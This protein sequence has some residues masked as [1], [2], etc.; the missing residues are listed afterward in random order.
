MPNYKIISDFYDTLDAIYFRNKEHS[1]RT[2]IIDMIPNESVC[3]LDVCAGTCSN[4]VLIAQNK[5]KAKITALDLSAKMLDIAEE[6][7]HRH[8]IKNIKTI[9]ADAKNSGLPSHSFDVIII[10]LVLHEMNEH[11]Q[12]A[13][14]SEAKR[15]LSDNGNIV[16]IEWEQ[17]KKLHQRFIFT[18]IKQ[19]EPKGFKYFL[20]LDLAEYFENSGFT[21]LEKRSCD[22]T[23]VYRLAR[24]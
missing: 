19:F 5:P 13:I 12:K 3:V 18:P 7:L 11:L 4:S 8:G 23:C 2:A 16:V 15:L 22:Y 9:V 17:P 1:P 6:K 24:R 21:V 10:S 14:L 20:R